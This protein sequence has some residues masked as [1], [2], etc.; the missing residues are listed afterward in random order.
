MQ[1]KFAEGSQPV[2]NYTLEKRLGEGTF[3]E[4]W[5]AVGPGGVPVALKLI[6]LTR[7]TGARELRSIL[8]LRDIRHP[9]LVPITGLWILDENGEVPDA[10]AP[11]RIDPVGRYFGIDIRKAF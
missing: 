11:E 4:V 5:R 6:A 10:F 2:P 8:P 1:M 3:G 9:H 7:A